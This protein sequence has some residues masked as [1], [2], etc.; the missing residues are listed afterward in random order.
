MVVR[1]VYPET[2]P[3]AR[4]QIAI[5]RHPEGTQEAPSDYCKF[6]GMCWF[7]IA[8]TLQR[9]LSVSIYIYIYIYI[10]ILI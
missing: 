5:L 8:P 2:D 6:P 3:S 10:Y 1:N 7:F 4:P 9:G